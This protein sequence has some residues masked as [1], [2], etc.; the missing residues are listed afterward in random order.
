VEAVDITLMRGGLRSILFWFEQTAQKDKKI[1]NKIQQYKH[2]F[3]V[4]INY[5][6][7]RF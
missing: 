1:F 3:L 7:I 4:K 2:Y 6:K 5:N